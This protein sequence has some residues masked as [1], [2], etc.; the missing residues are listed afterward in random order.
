[1]S[2]NPLPR[3]AAR[4]LVAA[5]VLVLA[6]LAAAP[7]SAGPYRGIQTH[8]LWGATRSEDIPK[9]MQLSRDVGANMV[10]VDV[11]WSSLETNGKGDFASWYVQKLDR[12]VNEADARGIKVMVTLWGTPCWASSAPDS[13]RQNCEGSWWDRGV[14]QYPPRNPADYG[15]IA[16]WV[17][18][19]YGTKL[20]AL[21][22][23]NEANLAGDR[24]WTSPDEVGDYAALVRAAYAPAKAG[25]PNVPVLAGALAAAD[26]PW[27]D[28]L[29]ARGIKGYYDGISI[30][31][32]NEWRDPSDM[33]QE[34]WKMYTLIPG[35]R[36]IREGQLAAGD[37]TPIWITEYGWP[38][39][40]GGR[41]C[42][43]EAKQ[44]AYTAESV[45]LLEAIP[46]LAAYTIYDL[47]NEGT[48]PTRMDDNFGLVR[49]DYSPKPVYPALRDAWAGQAPPP[50][51]GT[52]TDTGT[53][54]GSDSGGSQ[55]RRRHGRVKKLRVKRGR[56]RVLVRGKAPAGST[57]VVVQCPQRRC[58]EVRSAR[59]V[60]R[61]AR[62]GSNGRFKVKMPRIRSSRKPGVRA[63]VADA[64]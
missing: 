60:V 27:L 6:L 49:E 18:N 61:T 63:H 29:Y 42:V 40:E 47:R 45:G 10:R 55:P 22:V 2:A 8:S 19:R 12:L 36:W 51:P 16:R 32:Y 13:A 46:Y 41:W 59:A 64:G 39:C 50:D 54:T 25:N 34:Q 28:Q 35:T 20:A 26:R 43:S 30:H 4:A 15:D 17:T 14:V 57:V 5:S 53:D 7:A 11:G 31:P 9:E 38:T 52:G 37:N 3:L 48:D 24:F 1:V 23:W 56:H 62:V 33:W 44:A 58:P 21:E